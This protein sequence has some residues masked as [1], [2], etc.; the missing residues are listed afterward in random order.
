MILDTR[1]PSVEEVVQTNAIFERRRGCVLRR[2][3][4]V[5][6]VGENA[7]VRELAEAP[8]LAIGAGR[9]LKTRASISSGNAAGKAE[10]QGTM[11]IKNKL[12]AMAVAAGTII[13]S[14]VA[15]DAWAA[16]ATKNGNPSAPG[17][18]KANQ[19]SPGQVS[20][21]LAATG[22]GQVKIMGD[23]WIEYPSV[24][25]AVGVGGPSAHLKTINLKGI[26]TDSGCAFS[27]SATSDDLGVSP[28]AQVYM[29]E[30]AYN[31]DSCQSRF[32]VAQVTPEQLALISELTGA[33]RSQGGIGGPQDTPAELETMVQ[34]DKA[35]TN[36]SVAPH[37]LAAVATYTKTLKAMIKDPPGLVT[38]S[39]STA[40]TWTATSS[41]V[42][43]YS[44]AHSYSWMSVTGWSRSSY[45]QPAG[46]IGSWTAVYGDTTGSFSNTAFCLAVSI[47]SPIGA[48]AVG[49]W[50]TTYSTHSQTRVEGRPGG[51]WAWSYSMTKSGGCNL[52]LHY[53][54]QFS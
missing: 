6:I 24:L 27:G 45:S 41:S 17:Q 38:T 53:D 34:V 51:G 44:V 18:A 13:G 5:H 37:A 16:P 31:P 9:G 47:L 33:G 21:S 49:G 3:T 29:T 28:D 8:R 20:G 46:V 50:G 40:L 7:S 15:S 42:T 12:V 39:T 26:K 36:P 19:L 22:H 30:V 48:L 43:S 14:A 54:Y 10:G 32:V 11:N 23:G 1:V 52:L 4:K 25:E 35:R 2:V